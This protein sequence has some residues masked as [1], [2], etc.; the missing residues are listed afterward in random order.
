MNTSNQEI[1]RLVLSI[2]ERMDNVLKTNRGDILRKYEGN[3]DGL[4]SL[5]VNIFNDNQACSNDFDIL[6]DKL[7]QLAIKRI[8]PKALS[9]FVIDEPDDCWSEFS[10]KRLPRLLLDF[11]PSKA[12]TNNFYTVFRTSFINFCIS[13]NKRKKADEIKQPEMEETVNKTASGTTTIQQGRHE[14]INKIIALEETQLML[15]IFDNLKAE[16]REKLVYHCRVLLPDLIAKKWIDIVKGYQNQ[17]FIQVAQGI[18][19]E[20]SVSLETT[21]HQ[22]LASSKAQMNDESITHDLFLQDKNLDTK[23]DS[24]HI[25]NIARKIKPKFIKAMQKHIREYAEYRR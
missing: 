21:T 9:V 5:F 14:N 6:Y 8:A 12:V 25:D 18:E 13:E 19:H 11:D 1:N 20:Y 2:Q 4:F 3:P 10:I 7:Q 22:Y 16:V 24:D 15:D 17:Y 23:K